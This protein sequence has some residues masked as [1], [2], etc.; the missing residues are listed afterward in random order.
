[1]GTMATINQ[2][3]SSDQAIAVARKFGFNAIVKEA[4]DEVVVEQEEDK[5]ELLSARPPVVTVL[6][7]VDHGKTSLLDKIRYRQRR[8]GRSRRHHAE[9]R[10]V[11]RREDDR[12]ITFIDTPGHEAFTAMRARGAK[13]TDVA[14][15]VVAADDG[16]MPQTKEAISHIKAAGVPIVVAINKMDKED[17]QPDRVK[18]QLTDEGLQPVEWG[19]KIEMVPVSAR[20]GEGIDKLLETV[21]LEA[22]IRELKANKMRRATGVVIESALDRGRGAVATVLVQNGTLARRRRHRRRR[23]PTARFARSPTTRANK[24][25]RP[26]LRSRSR[27]WGSPTFRRRATR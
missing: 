7:H 4:G 15:L 23:R 26:A 17:A 16:V 2:N 18:Q 5:P 13:V 22:D 3:I 9:D 8:G 14:I 24:L 1:M 20:T 25:R 10:R 12:K 6:G 21:L 27:S 19:G 11:Y